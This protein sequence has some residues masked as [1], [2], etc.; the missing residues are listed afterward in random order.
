MR[1]GAREAVAVNKGA[2]HESWRH[3]ADCRDPDAHPRHARLAARSQLGLPSQWSRRCG[4][5][6]RD[7]PVLDGAPV[8]P[9]GDG[10]DNV[11]NQ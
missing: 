10:G 6:N 9:R 1:V 5:V 11:R 2:S 7:R 8:I 4:T 3:S